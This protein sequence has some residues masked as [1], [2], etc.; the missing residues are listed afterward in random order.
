VSFILDAL[1]KSE[2]ERRRMSTP[3]LAHIP[4]ATPRREL[5][6]WTLIVIGVL[7]AAVLGLGGAWWQS[8]QTRL[9]A[10]D[11]A[12]APVTTTRE[13]SIPPPTPTAALPTATAPAAAASANRQVE[14]APIATRSLSQGAEFEAPH[15]APRDDTTA[16]APASFAAAAAPTAN[17]LVLPSAASLAAEGIALPQLRLELHAYTERPKDR[18]VFINGRK[19]VEGERLVDGPE[20]LTIAPNGAVLRYLGQRFLLTPE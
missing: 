16:S 1:R 15:A 9:D 12:A 19:Y 4:L 2:H 5:P 18:F 14:R 20:V 10:A 11:V 3:V 7:T 6:R 8:A 17:D 13:L